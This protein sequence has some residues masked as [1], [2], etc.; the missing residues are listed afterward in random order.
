MKL[1][2]MMMALMITSGAFATQ[3]DT[4]CIAM[5]ESREKVIKSVQSKSKT[6]KSAIAR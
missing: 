5:N 4:D 6:V 2:I 1:M 3:V